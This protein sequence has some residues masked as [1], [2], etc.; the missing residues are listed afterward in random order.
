MTRRIRKPEKYKRGTP[1]RDRVEPRMR[2]RGY[3]T[4]TLQVIRFGGGQV[5]EIVLGGRIIGKYTAKID[6]LVLFETPGE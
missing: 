2:A 3:D 5:Y 4:N 6:E 1:I